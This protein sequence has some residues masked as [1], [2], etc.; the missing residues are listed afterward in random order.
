M[1]MVPHSIAKWDCSRA[2]MELPFAGYQL[3]GG[4]LREVF[5]SMVAIPNEDK[6]EWHLGTLS[7]SFRRPL[8]IRNCRRNREYDP[9]GEWVSFPD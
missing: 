7:P 1:A 6:L 4:I 3:C 8:E 2:K 5:E 9:A